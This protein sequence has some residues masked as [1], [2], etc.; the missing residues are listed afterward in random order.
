MFRE[1]GEETIQPAIFF[2]EEE[3]NDQDNSSSNRLFTAQEVIQALEKLLLLVHNGRELKFLL[4]RLRGYSFR[5]ISR[6]THCS[7]GAISRFFLRVKKS[8]P[9][10]GKFLEYLPNWVEK[11]EN[12]FPL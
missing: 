3:E 5:E 1:N 6:E 2:D 8:S 10:V 4:L 7:H 9:E 11:E 12:L